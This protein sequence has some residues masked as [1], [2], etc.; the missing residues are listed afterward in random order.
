MKCQILHEIILSVMFIEKRPTILFSIWHFCYWKT[1]TFSCKNRNRRRMTLQ[2]VFEI[3]FAPN[4]TSCKL[5]IK[6]R[7]E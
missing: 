4:N 1:W 6:Q 3:L 7:E 2:F 5:N